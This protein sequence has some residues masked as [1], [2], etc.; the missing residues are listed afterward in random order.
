MLGEFG[1]RGSDSEVYRIYTI[2]SRTDIDW[3]QVVVTD[4]TDVLPPYNPEIT[5]TLGNIPA[6]A[7]YDLGAWFLCGSG[8]GEALEC[9]NG[10]ADG[11]GGDLHGCVSER[12]DAGTETVKF[13]TSCDGI[14]D[15]GTLLIRVIART[16][17]G[18]CEPYEL[19][20]DLN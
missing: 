6:G 9:E 17:T 18:V 7:D 4:E 3:F 5:L 20:F 14:D 8:G 11:L 13:Q 2:D 15:S 19:T 10:R 12:R 1:D 16:Y